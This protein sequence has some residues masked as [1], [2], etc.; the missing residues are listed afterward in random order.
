MITATIKSHRAFGFF[1]NS[2][3]ALVLVA[4]LAQVIS[5]C[6]HARILDTDDPILGMPFRYLMF[7]DGLVQLSV[8]GLCL[9]RP[10][11]LLRLFLLIWVA[12]GILMYRFGLWEIDWRRP[13]SCLGN[14]LDVLHVG[15]R[16]AEWAIKVLLMYFSVG[17]LAAIV[18]HSWLL[19]TKARICPPRAETIGQ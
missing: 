9:Y 16:P 17:G 14:L 3:L 19:L 5:S 11:D 10:H 1:I 6:G 7:I 4:G 13:C 15:T 12:S 2:C 18:F 8:F